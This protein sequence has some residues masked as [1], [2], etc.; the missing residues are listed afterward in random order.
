M[1]Y[2]LFLLF[3]FLTPTIK[4]DSGKTIQLKGNGP[5]LLF[6]TGLF[7]TMPNFLYNNIQNKLSKNFTLL[8]NVDYKP[9]ELSD[10][11]NIIDEI[12]VDY[13]SFFAHSSIDSKIL[14]SDNFNKIIVCDPITVPNFN[15]DGFSNQKI[16]PSAS[17]LSI[18]AEKLYNSDLTLPQYQDP[19]ILNKKLINEIIYTDVGHPDI[20]DNIWADLAIFSRLWKGATSTKN[21]KKF[22]EWKYIKNKNINKE[23]YKKREDY[24]NFIVKEIINFINEN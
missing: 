17:I 21:I 13:L 23:V 24:R 22:K 11:D 16:K 3:S 5:P 10:I 15:L 20:L 4:L 2:T 9:F 7:G 12:E 14:E 18:K 1:Y 6:S 19:I 8:L